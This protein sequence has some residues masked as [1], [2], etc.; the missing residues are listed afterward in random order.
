MA[1]LRAGYRKALVAQLLGVVSPRAVRS[2]PPVTFLHVGIAP[3]PGGSNR[4][5][6]SKAVDLDLGRS[7]LRGAA[8]LSALRKGRRAMP[9]HGNTHLGGGHRK[10][11][12]HATGAPASPQNVHHEAP[13]L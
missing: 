8:V 1:W 12:V 11:K 5:N 2:R 10:A 7:L 13:P 6:R 9:L 3:D 4:P